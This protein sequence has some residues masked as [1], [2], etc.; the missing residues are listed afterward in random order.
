MDNNDRLPFTRKNYIIM[1]I[2]IATLVIGFTI[3]SLDKEE[4]GFGVLGLTVGPVIV[5]MGFIIQFFAIM[6]NS[7]SKK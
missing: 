4:F 3:M 6:H 5:M 1:I 2:G 7:K